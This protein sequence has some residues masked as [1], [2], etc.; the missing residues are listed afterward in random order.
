MEQQRPLVT[1]PLASTTVH[2]FSS[3]F[4]CAS[5][6]CPVLDL[7]HRKGTKEVKRKVGGSNLSSKRS[8]GNLA[9]AFPLV[10]FDRRL[11]HATGNPGD[12]RDRERERVAR[13]PA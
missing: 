9:S 7:H 11:H 12:A 2:G 3:D 4:T 5:S 1:S 6:V 10:L 8:A 13:T